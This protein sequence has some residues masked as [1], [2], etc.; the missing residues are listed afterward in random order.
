M[1]YCFPVLNRIVLIINSAVDFMESVY[2]EEFDMSEFLETVFEKGAEHK[3]HFIMGV[4]FK[5]YEECSGYAAFNMACDM[6]T[7]LHLGGELSEQRIFD[8]DM[9]VGEYEKRSPAGSAVTIADGETIEIMT[10]LEA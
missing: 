4:S 7:G 6:Q 5:E 10:P 8:F 2:N 9:S 1:I 3:I